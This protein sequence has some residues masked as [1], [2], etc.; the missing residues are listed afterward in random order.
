MSGSHLS[1]IPVANLFSTEDAIGV[2]PGQWSTAL[3]VPQESIFVLTDVIVFPLVWTSDPNFL[4]A[5]GIE[6]HDPGARGTYTGRK[7]R[8]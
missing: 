1:G 7:F 2:D 5:F 4:V 6:E 8:I 3:T